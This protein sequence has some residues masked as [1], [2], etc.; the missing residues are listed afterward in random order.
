[1]R[2]TRTFTLGEKAQECGFTVNREILYCSYCGEQAK[3]D[4]AGSSHNHRWEENIVYYCECKLAVKESKLKED[5]STLK[6]KLFHLERE[7]KDMKRFENN[8]IVNKMKF[9][10]EVEGLK[11]KFQI[12]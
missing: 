10:K 3:E 2:E 6:N 7:L 12:K 9:N 4:D 5:M 8:E 1:M 11:K